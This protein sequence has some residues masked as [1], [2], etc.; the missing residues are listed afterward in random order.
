MKFPNIFKNQLK[1]T[2]EYDKNHMDN[3]ENFD[4]VKATM[5]ASYYWV[6]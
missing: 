4:E 2:V 1:S 6:K 5:T 3:K